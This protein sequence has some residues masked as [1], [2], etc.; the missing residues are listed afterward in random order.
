MSL[1]FVLII[2]LT[3]KNGYGARGAQ[4]YSLFNAQDHFP[5]NAQWAYKDCYLS[6]SKHQ[7]YTIS[8]NFQKR[9]NDRLI[10][11]NNRI[12]RLSSIGVERTQ[13]YS[14]PKKSEPWSFGFPPQLPTRVGRFFI[15]LISYLLS[16]LSQAVLLG[17][18]VL[19]PFFEKSVFLFNL[20][21]G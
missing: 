8:Q 10:A 4:G 18:S 11:H 6:L 14:T 5:Y 9:F 20:P 12:A 3:N 17:L 1:S 7:A 16:N 13:G 15:W 19:W 21:M 2:N